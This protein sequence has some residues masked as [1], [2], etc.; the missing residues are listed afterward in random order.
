MVTKN[1][2]VILVANVAKE[3]ILK[4]HIPTINMLKENGWHV[5]VACSGDAE[6]LAC[7]HQYNMPYKRNPF[8][9]K[10]I[11]GI[12]ALR[13]ILKEEKYDVISCHTP[14]GGVVGRLATIGLKNKPYVMYTAHGFHFYRG[15]PLLNWL[16]YF[17]VEWV[18]SYCTDELI[19]INNEDYHIAKRF[20]FGMKKLALI[21]GMGVDKERF[22]ASFS[23]AEKEKT[24]KELRIPCDEFVY[25][26]VAEV[27][28]NK[29]QKVLLEAI[30]NVREKTGKGLLLLVG[31]IHDGGKCQ[32]LAEELGISQYV[33]FTGWRSDVEKIFN[34]TD[35]YVASSIREGLGLNLIEAQFSNLPV[36]ASMNRGHRDIIQDGINGF[37]ARYNIANDFAEKMVLLQQNK[38]IM[39]EIANKG[40]ITS[41]KY[42]RENSIKAI[43]K[44]YLEV[45]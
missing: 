30:K 35:V 24:R 45:E 38:S 42:S 22:S 23:D 34:I 16:V 31:P 11:S 27:I 3:H 43:E 13:K 40:S 18:L 14:T 28:A 7:D 1:K 37:L 44:I 15:A 33:I 10:T 39:R 8:S 17:P 21:P 12:F 32:E 5:D 6:V 36:I 20:H 25:T 41:E 29:N 4:F 2:K 26:Y 19:V 9:L